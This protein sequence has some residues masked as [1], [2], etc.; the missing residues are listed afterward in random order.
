MPPAATSPLRLPAV[1][2]VDLDDTLNDFTATLGQ[3]PFPYHA[4]Y[5]LP[6]D[7]FHGYLEK[8]RLNAPEASDLQSTEFTFF[9]AKIHEQCYRQTRP[10]AEGLEFMRWLKKHGCRIVICTHRDLRRSEQSTRQWL[11][12]HDVPFDHLFMA[13]NKIVFCAAWGI[14]H[15]VDDDAFNIEHGAKYGVTV[16]YP[17]MDKHRSPP[18]SG[19]RGFHSFEEVKRWIQE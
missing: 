4:S 8:V 17:L 5:R 13:R 9:C 2:A 1:I 19:A 12:E 14:K 11:G 15:L 10:R 16:F 3:A 7:T 6:E 18:A